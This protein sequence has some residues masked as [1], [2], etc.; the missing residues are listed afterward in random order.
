MT[1]RCLLSMML[2]SSL[3]STTSHTGTV[4]LGV[5]TPGIHSFHHKENPLSCPNKGMA[6]GEGQLQ[7]SKLTFALW[8]GEKQS[9][10]DV[11]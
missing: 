8:I 9:H 10:T 1:W 5:R 2:S 6:G 4:R 11:S 7:G 3:P